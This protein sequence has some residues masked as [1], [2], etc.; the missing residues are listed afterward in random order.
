MKLHNF[1]KIVRAMGKDNMQDLIRR[2]GRLNDF[3]EKPD[4]CNEIRKWFN[5][6][7]LQTLAPLQYLKTQDAYIQAIVNSSATVVP[8][9]E[10]RFDA[11]KKKD[12]FW[13]CSA[14]PG[15]VG[16]EH[17]V[18]AE[19]PLAHFLLRVFRRLPPLPVTAVP[20]DATSVPA[21][22]AEA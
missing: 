1:C 20:T 8:E 22:E 4:L 17:R 7:V 18:E 3:I 12:L 10:K 16:Y 6:C 13:F 11:W 9:L 15:A 19:R 14:P 5:N 21:A 2:M